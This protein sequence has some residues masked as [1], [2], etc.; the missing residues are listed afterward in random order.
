MATAVT[1]AFLTAL[2]T[3]HWAEGDGLSRHLTAVV[4]L[5]IGGV[6]AA[7]FAGKLTKHIPVRAFTWAVGG[8]V[9]L[10]AIYKA[11]LLFNVV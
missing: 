1:G 3:G 10:L 5:I 11:L 8:L 4:G 7:P 9:V 6:I 2:L